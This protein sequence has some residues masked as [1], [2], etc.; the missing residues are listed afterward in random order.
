MNKEEPHQNALHRS[1]HFTTR[2]GVMVIPMML[3]P[4]STKGR[5]KL[6]V[7]SG[8]IHSDEAIMEIDD[9]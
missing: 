9:L 6:S 5:R 3:S 4:Q 8:A 1:K 2:T 7:K